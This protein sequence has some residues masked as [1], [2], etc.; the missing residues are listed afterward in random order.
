M[1][2][3]QKIK[4][5]HIR[6]AGQK[7]QSSVMYIGIQIL[8][9]IIA[10]VLLFNSKSDSLVEVS[11]LISLISSVLLIAS[12]VSLNSA[13][14]N[15]IAAVSFTHQP[16]KSLDEFDPTAEEN[17]FETEYFSN[18]KIKVKKSFSKGG[19]KHGVW[20]YYLENG[21][22]DYKEFYQNGSW[23]QNIR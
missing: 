4:I 7:I 20:E 21:D 18:G 23:V 16:A 2:E 17:Y 5:D 8:F 6:K 3:E 10:I 15:L 13:G 19:V 9:T 22:L 12:L 14:F 1:D 11:V